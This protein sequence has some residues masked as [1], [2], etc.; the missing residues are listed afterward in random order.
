MSDKRRLPRWNQ[1]DDLPIRGKLT[2]L[3]LLSSALGLL[4]TAGILLAHVSSTARSSTVRDLQ[5]LANIMADSTVAALA[6]GDP[7]AATDTLGSLKAHSDIERACLY[8]GGPVL[9]RLDGATLFAEFVRA[10]R[11]CPAS[12]TDGSLAQDRDSLTV[13]TP[14]QLGQDRLGTLQLTENLQRQH[15]ALWLLAALALGIGG[16]SF[17][18]SGALAWIMQRAITA[19]LLRLAQTAQHVSETRDYDVRVEPAGGDEVGRL[20]GD[21]NQMLEQ[22]AH[23]EAALNASE[24]ELRRVNQS[25]ETQVHETRHALQELRSTQA[26]LLQSEK[27]ASLGAMVAGLAHE[28]NTPLGVGVSAASTLQALAEQIRLRHDSGQMTRSDLNRF[29]QLAIDSADMVLRNLQR[30]ADLIQSFKQVAVDQASDERR[31]FALKSYLDE[32]IVSLSPKF[33]STRHRVT[34][35]CPADLMLDSYP[36][37]LAQIVTNFITNSLLHGFADGREG[38]IEI[39]VT[40]D[41]STVALHYRDDGAG[42]PAAHLDR[43]FDPFFT[44]RRGSGGSGLGLNVVYNVV[45]QRLGG[46]VKVRSEPGRGCEFIVQFPL[47]SAA[48]AAVPER[49]RA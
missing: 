24:S 12:P 18:S 33:R 1:L 8:G 9:K 19:P 43:V 20:I 45:Q 37:A 14:V 39:D 10:G 31:R 49:I 7:H 23:R 41:G 34:V 15:R 6:F 26:Q 35:R 13:T 47:Q 5:T 28:I 4:L 21:F 29:V 44:T 42:I 48:P 32:V 30:A 17:L 40:H 2:L 22:I 25:L 11:A 46:T 3:V 16:V 36:G 27:L 38:H